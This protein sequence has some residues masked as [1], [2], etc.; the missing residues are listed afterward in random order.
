MYALSMF[1][2]LALRLVKHTSLDLGEQFGHRW[3]D[4]FERDSLLFPCVTADY[5]SLLILNV[6]RSHLDAQGNS[7][8]LPF[9]EFP[10]WRLVVPVV[11]LHPKFTRERLQ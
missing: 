8:Q 1:V 7:A 9:V 11:H 6:P 10:T 2:E 4:G 3:S 5:D